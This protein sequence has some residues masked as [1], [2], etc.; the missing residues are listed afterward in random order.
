MMDYISNSAW[1]LIVGHIFLAWFMVGCKLSTL[2]I[3]F[4]IGLVGY[5]IV[6]TG[7]ERNS[8]F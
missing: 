2:H 7:G 6:K 5:K 3:K 1:V 8:H 4:V